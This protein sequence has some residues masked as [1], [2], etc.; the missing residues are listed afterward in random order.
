MATNRI[1]IHQSGPSTSFYLDAD[2]TFQNVAENYTDVSIWM[3]AYNGGGGTTGSQYN[4]AG[5]QVAR[6]DGHGEVGR[7][8]GNPF[9]PSGYGANQLRWSVGPFTRRYY[10]DANGYL[11]EVIVEMQVAYGN[12]NVTHRASIGAP[13]RIP[14]RPNA[15][16]MDGVADITTNSM[17]VYYRRGADNGAGI[18]Q[19]RVHWRQASDDAL[20][21]SDENAGGYSNPAGGAGPSLAPGTQYRIAVAS[22]NAVGWSDWSASAFGTTLSADAPGLLVTPR[23]T[24]TIARMAITPPGGTSGVTEWLYRVRPVGGTATEYSHNG[25][26]LDILDLTPGATYDFQA[27]VRYGSYTSPWSGWVRATMPSPN[28][29]PG[30]YYDGGSPTAA[31]VS[32]VWAGTAENSTSSVIGKAVTGWRTFAQGSGTSGGTGVVYRVTGGLGPQGGEFRAR[33]VFFSD[34][35]TSGFAGGQSAALAHLSVVAPGAFYFGSITVSPSRAQRMN[36]QIYWYSATG[37]F[38]SVS[39]GIPA[40]VGA[41]ETVRLVASGTAPA[42]AAR[43]AVVWRDLTGTGWSTWKGGDSILADRGMISIELYDYFDGD[44]IVPGYQFEWVGDPNA[45]PSLRRGGGLNDSDF[46]DPLLDPDCAPPPEPP[47]P[48]VILDD[49]VE[50]VGLWRRYWIPVP[51]GE[52]SAWMTEVPTLE[53]S[54]GGA[55]ERQVRVRYFANPYGLAPESAQMN[56]DWIA[57]QVISYIPAN[58]TITL[59]GISER[60][61][62]QVDED[63]NV[64]SADHLLYGTNGE[65]ATWPTFSCGIGYLVALDVP[66]EGS[67]SNLSTS[68]YLTQRS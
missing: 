64:L 5:D 10:H 27:A 21:W 18:I 31:D 58:T 33:T 45:S 28:T 42:G 4:G 32:Y 36:A 61:W 40:V 48:P 43:A 57:E 9:L 35:S 17:G 41:N 8:S 55:A 68:L 30:D 44:S 65:P 7:R 52:I 13:A 24:G 15:P 26:L 14:K 49:C 3:S 38:I 53:I 37:A 19:D 60:A 23:V 6:M 46:Y 20:V 51:P 59:D 16:I 11:G 34:A 63:P 54:T 56:D 1:A 39:T 22:L 67:A 12:V 50:D 47:R 29:N 25:N 66:L 2:F 62:A